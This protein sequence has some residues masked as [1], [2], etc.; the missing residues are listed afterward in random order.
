MNQIKWL[1]DWY[2]QN[3][4]NEWEHF[5]GLE[6]KTLDNPGWYV[7][8]DLNETKYQNLVMEK[9]RREIGEDDWI[10]CEITNGVFRGFGDSQK[11][12]KILDVFINLVTSTL[13]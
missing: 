7:N 12:E 8:I 9:I 4:I 1:Q 10:V 13:K 5:Y 3:C 6:I 11:L 2:T